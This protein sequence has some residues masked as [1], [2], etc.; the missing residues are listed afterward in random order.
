[1]SQTVN[2]GVIR[3]GAR[4]IF[5]RAVAR[6]LLC[7]SKIQCEIFCIISTSTGHKCSR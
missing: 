2:A 7:S 6:I 4:D 3:D 1:M 5:G